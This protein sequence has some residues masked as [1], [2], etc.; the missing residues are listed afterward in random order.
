[1][2]GKVRDPGGGTMQFY[3]GWLDL[4][5]VLKKTGMSYKLPIVADRLIGGV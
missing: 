4:K 2:L 1:M 5:S 3:V